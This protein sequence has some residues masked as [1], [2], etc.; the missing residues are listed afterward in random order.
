VRVILCQSPWAL[1]LHTLH[2]HVNVLR[3]WGCHHS[4][5][6]PCEFT[7]LISLT[8]WGYGIKMSPWKRET[9]LCTF[10]T[11]I[12]FWNFPT[13]RT[14]SSR[15]LWFWNYQGCCVFSQKDKQ[16]KICIVTGWWWY[17]QIHLKMFP[18]HWSWEMGK[19]WKRLDVFAR[20]ARIV[21]NGP[22]HVRI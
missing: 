17:F 13:S 12:L 9:S 18:Q 20:R 2:T 7:V 1:C 15:C 16:T 14:V 11:R 10:T 4:F 19:Q 8:M 22:F 5:I 21:T 6:P 3:V